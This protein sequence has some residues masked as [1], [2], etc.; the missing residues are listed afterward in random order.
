MK[1][2][3]ILT[4]DGSTTISLPEWDECYHSTHGAVSESNHIFIEA[5]L[6]YVLSRQTQIRLLEVGFGTG[7][8]AFLSAMHCMGSNHTLYY[9][10]LEPYPLIE[11]E[12][13]ALNYP[14]ISGYKEHDACFRKIHATEWVKE[15]LITPQFTLVKTRQPIQEATL[16][17][18]Y[19]D[20]VYFDAFAPRVQPELWQKNIFEKLHRAMQLGGILVT[21]SCKGDVKRALKESGFTLEK[22]PGP[23]GKRE[24]IRAEK[25]SV[26]YLER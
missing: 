9:I 7:L 23:K 15:S 2:E 17:E 26:Q 18:N 22:L 5:G 21:Y 4:D 1:R 13:K 6:K 10:G 14:E 19:F 25:S 3:I 8:N 11:T 16:P 24:F 20:L 12:I